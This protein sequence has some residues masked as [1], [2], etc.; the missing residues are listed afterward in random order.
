M[1]IFS[2]MKRHGIASTEIRKGVVITSAVQRNDDRTGLAAPRV[3]TDKRLSVN[4]VVITRT[5]LAES[6]VIGRVLTVTA[7]GIVIED[8]AAP[9]AVWV[10]I[11]GGALGYGHRNRAVKSE[12]TIST[13]ET[14]V[15]S[16][17]SD[18][19]CSVMANIGRI[20]C[21]RPRHSMGRYA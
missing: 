4:I 17:S 21:T 12:V 8:N 16:L 13:A 20:Y 7:R 11:A 5:I 19:V 10:D 3:W 6:I 9:S 2:D 18:V 1:G 15:A 14:P